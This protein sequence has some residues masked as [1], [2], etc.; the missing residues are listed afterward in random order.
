MRMA[1]AGLSRPNLC[2]MRRAGS[3]SAACSIRAGEELPFPGDLV[4]RQT[5]DT[6][7]RSAIGWPL[8]SCE[9]IRLL[10]SKSA[11]VRYRPPIATIVQGVNDYVN[12][13]ND[14]GLYA[15]GMNDVERRVDAAIEAGHA[16]LTSVSS[17]TS[18][19]ARADAASRL[20]KGLRAIS[21]EASGVLHEEAIRIYESEGL[22]YG[23]IAKRLGISKTLAHQIIKARGLD[24]DRASHSTSMTPPS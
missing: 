18:S 8:W 6:A 19:Q 4:T 14:Q 7:G 21:D 16:A 13:L 10:T 15:N 17:M 1:L 22:S 11:G 5:Q 23:Q 9:A 2:G 20:S 3:A 24:L 12:P